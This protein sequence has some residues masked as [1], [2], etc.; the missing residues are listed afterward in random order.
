VKYDTPIDPD[1]PTTSHG[2]VAR[3]VG[4]GKRVLDVGCG[5]GQLADYL[6]SHGNEV[7]GVEMDP[8][9]AELARPHLERL[10]VGDLDHLDLVAELGAGSFDVIVCA[11]VL[12]H[13]RNP[14]I[15]LRQ[16]RALLVDGGY[17]V[18][19]IPNVAHG[20]VR[21]ALLQGRFEYR[22]LGLLD[23]THLR[24]FT[25]SSVVSLLRAAGFVP[26]ESLQ[27]TAGPFETEI[28]LSPGDF[29]AEVLQ[30]VDRDPDSR[31]Y[32]FVVR[33]LP[34]GTGSGDEAVVDEILAMDLE[35]HRLRG[36]LAAIAR[37][38]ENTPRRPV[39]GLLDGSERLS[40]FPALVRVRFTVLLAE[41][42]RRVIGFEVRAYGLSPEPTE[43]G[44]AGETVR[45]LSPWDAER[46]SQTRAEVEAVVV[47][48]GTAAPASLQRVLEDLVEAGCPLHTMMLE[49]P[50][51]SVGLLSSRLPVTGTTTAPT[52]PG[53]PRSVSDP[54][55]LAD[56]LVDPTSLTARA[57]YLRLRGTLPETAG[58]VLGY[59]TDVDPTTRGRAEQT[60]SSIARRAGT[61]LVVIDTDDAD[62][63]LAGTVLAVS[64]LAPIDLLATVASAGLVVTTSPALLALATSLGRPTLGVATGEPADILSLSV[65]P[66]KD[67]LVGRIDDLVALAPV[68]MAGADVDQRR[69]QAAGA[70]DLYFDDLAGV[71]VSEAA[72]QL[73]IS[74]PQR[75][76]ELAEQVTSLES[77]NAG[78]R[79]RL[80]KER[81]AIAQHLRHARLQDQLAAAGDAQVS[82][83]HALQRLQEEISAIYA[84]RTMRAAQPARRIYRRLRSLLR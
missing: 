59:W 56:R 27:T 12:E 11:D 39:I 81:T 84:T 13:L 80:A 60:L 9:S 73:S 4:S 62:S 14:L 77:V 57:D 40:E 44:L 34:V 46:S 17:L 25:W 64:E 18:T 35:V 10:V 67:Q 53:R 51:W 28:P 42:R 21:L 24:F 41:I 6:Q 33:A 5:T 66:T 26:A 76:A 31:T 75:L 16:V 52:T 68:A 15:T 29:S 69:D 65:S 3:L 48:A 71:L 47:L 36:E 2:L 20:S 63:G 82:D 30:E 19:S 1:D 54:L 72:R 32:Q 8:E 61:D 38:M 58:F 50:P 22:D 83:G 43:T 7:S 49:A 55:A 23:D 78:L 74:A 79:H 70:L 37:H 45:S